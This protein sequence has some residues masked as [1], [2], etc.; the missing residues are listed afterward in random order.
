MLSA[1]H[2]LVRASRVK[3]VKE[4]L[5][6]NVDDLDDEAQVFLVDRLALPPSWIFEAKVRQS[7][8]SGWAFFR[9]QLTVDDHV[10]GFEGQVFWGRLGRSSISS[11]RRSPR[12]GPRTGPR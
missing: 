12:P 3:A 11:R 1:C 10:T 6:R 4:L 2:P 8:W 5:A 7:I 9:V